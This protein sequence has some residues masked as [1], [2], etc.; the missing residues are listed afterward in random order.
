MISGTELIITSGVG[1]V[2]DV[3]EVSKMGVR[4]FASVLYASKPLKVGYRRVEP[5]TKTEKRTTVINTS[6]RDSK[7]TMEG[8]PGDVKVIEDKIRQSTC[9]NLT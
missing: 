2:K 5:K 1:A 4:I 9:R 7:S 6:H 8:F 3:C